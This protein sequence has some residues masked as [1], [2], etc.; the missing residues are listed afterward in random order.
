MIY[1]DFNSSYDKKFKG[2]L[3]IISSDYMYY[4]FVEKRIIFKSFYLYAGLKGLLKC[5]HVK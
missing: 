5:L 1:L 2:G 4:S 3:T